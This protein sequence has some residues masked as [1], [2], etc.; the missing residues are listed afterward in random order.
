[1]KKSL[2][3][4]A[5]AGAFAMPFASQAGSLTVAN[6]DITLSGGLAGGWAHDSYGN[7]G[8]FACPLQARHECAA[9]FLIYGIALIRTIQRDAGHVMLD[10]QQQGFARHA[11]SPVRSS[12]CQHS[13]GRCEGTNRVAS[14]EPLDGRAF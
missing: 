4:L 8:V 6:Q 2:L 12:E 11:S 10:V 3:T 14:G 1:M 7:V 5:I 9:H 13:R